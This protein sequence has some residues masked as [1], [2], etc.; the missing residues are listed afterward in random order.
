M[1]CNL[2][3]QNEDGYKCLFLLHWVV[4]VKKY[5]MQTQSHFLPANLTRLTLWMD[6]FLKQAMMLSTYMVKSNQVVL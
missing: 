2:M 4:K 3:Q 1:T 5:L 6:L